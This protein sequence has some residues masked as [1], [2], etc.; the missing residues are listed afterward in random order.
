MRLHYYV[1]IKGWVCMSSFQFHSFCTFCPRLIQIYFSFS[2]FVNCT[3]WNAEMY[4]NMPK[5]SFGNLRPVSNF[6]L[7][8]VWFV[9]VVT[10][11]TDILTYIADFHKPFMGLILNFMGLILTYMGLILTYIWL[12]WDLYWLIWDL[13]WVT[14]DLY[15]L[16]W[17]LYWL[18]W[19][20]Y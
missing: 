11:G 12:I 16:I 20:L 13:Y 8:L 3:L 14:W 17:D 19:D 6:L 18:I 5:K 2:L 1:L 4:K 10:F 15:W 9:A 7:P